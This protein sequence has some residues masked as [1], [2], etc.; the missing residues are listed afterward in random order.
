LTHR[1]TLIGISL[2]VLATLIWSGNFIIARGVIKT[3]PP[4]SLAFY[5]WVTATLILLPFAWKYVVKDGAVIKKHLLY[6]T[7]AAATG[8]SMFNTFVYIGGHHSEAINL[9]LIGTTS[10]PIMSIILAALFLNER[11]SF[12]RIIGMLVCL[13]GVLLLL[14]KGS[15]TGILSASFSPG[16]LWV[17][18]AALAFSIYNTLVK[19]KPQDIHPLSFL[20]PVFFIGTILLIPF[21]VLEWKQSGGF[22]ITWS[23]VSVILYL[24]LAASV[25]AFLIWNM[26]ISKLG[27]GRTALFGNLIPVFS[28]IEAVLILGEKITWVHYA[29]FGLVIAGLIIANI[30]RGGRSGKPM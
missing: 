2:A 8:V 27:S 18:A 5:R 6:F 24:G 13:T 21:Y 9:A 16:D 22:A 28:S 14:G 30:S 20:F 3:I 29:S 10:S 11:I 19:R 15:L 4:V 7:A 17:L 1:N 26:A 25:V 12:L 23:S